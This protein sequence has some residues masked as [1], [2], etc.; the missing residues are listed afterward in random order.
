MVQSPLNLIR[1]YTGIIDLDVQAN[2]RICKANIY[3]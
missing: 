1:A 3:E 2:I